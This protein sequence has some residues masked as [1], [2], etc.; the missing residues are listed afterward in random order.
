MKKRLDLLSWS[1]SKQN[2]GYGFI[3]FTKSLKFKPMLEIRTT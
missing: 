2:I 1:T 3:L